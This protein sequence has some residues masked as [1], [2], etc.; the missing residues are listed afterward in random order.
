MLDE[1]VITAIERVIVGG[2]A[3]T[4]RALGDETSDL[5]LMQW[6]VLVV[7]GEQETGLHVGMVGQRIGTTPP[8]ASRIIRRLE[9]RGLIE[10]VRDESDRRFMLVRLTRKGRALRATLVDRR[11]MLIRSAFESHREALPSDLA[12]ALQAIAS[13]LLAL[14]RT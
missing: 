4:A 5:T 12:D 11:R 3:I 2:V 9:D 10:L 1:R 8:S 7:V 14:G 6:R 13:V